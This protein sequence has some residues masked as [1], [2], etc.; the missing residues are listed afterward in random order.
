MENLTGG[1]PPVR[2]LPCVVPCKLY[3]AGV[4]TN[5]SQAGKK[6]QM[7]FIRCFLQ[8]LGAD[9]SGQWTRR[10]NRKH[11]LIYEIREEIITVLMLS[12]YGHYDDK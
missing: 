6:Q 11:P 10:I 2:P 9:R 3:F 7:K 1:N 12:A 5:L 8:P 4:Q